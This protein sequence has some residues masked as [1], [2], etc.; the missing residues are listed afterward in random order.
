M[1]SL[2]GRQP[3]LSES[4]RV[5]GSVC[6]VLGQKAEVGFGPWELTSCVGLGKLLYLS[7]PKVILCEIDKS[8][9]TC[10]R[11]PCPVISSWRKE[12]ILPQR[13]GSG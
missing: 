12:L 11:N 13:V 3:P 8:P 4:S 10:P 9:C 2:G 6:W 1:Q 5:E 7:E